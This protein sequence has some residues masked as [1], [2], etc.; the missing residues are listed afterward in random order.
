MENEIL[1]P[2]Y[3]A[4]LDVLGFKELVHQV[5][6]PEIVHRIQDTFPHAR[7]YAGSYAKMST[8]EQRSVSGTIKCETAHFSDT[9]LIWTPKVNDDNRIAVEEVFYL[10]VAN[11]IFYAFI[12][13]VPFRAGVAFG[14]VYVDPVRNI[15]VG[16]PIIDAH[17]T[18]SSQDWIGGAL[19]PECRLPCH[20]DTVP[21]TKYP[22]PRK[23]DPKRTATS[24]PISY[25]IDWTWPAQLPRRISGQNTGYRKRLI[26]AFEKYLSRPMEELVA[27]KYR[28]A[29]IFADLQ[30]PAGHK[31]WIEIIRRNRPVSKWSWQRHR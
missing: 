5:K 18:E 30:V 19:H 8:R 31:R 26:G 15:F 20:F 10:A 16:Q 25:A 17:L 6:V 13:D 12:N 4:M 28:N 2:R 1:A 27:Q 14:E 7:G 23:H 9:L 21:V 3:V 22:V 11:T 29:K 24:P